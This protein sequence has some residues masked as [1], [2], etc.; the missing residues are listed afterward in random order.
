LAKASPEVLAQACKSLVGCE[1]AADYCTICDQERIDRLKGRMSGLNEASKAHQKGW[2]EAQ[3]KRGDARDR[4]WGKGEGLKFEGGSIA[5]FGKAGLDSVLLASGGGGGVG[6][7]YSSVT[8]NYR[9]VRDWTEKG[10]ALGSDPGN[11]ETWTGFGKDM[12]EMQADDIFRRRSTEAL[13]S[14]RE[15]FNKTGNYVG[16]Q[17]V[18]REKWGNYGR[19]KDFKG[20]AD[21]F[22]DALNK[23][24]N[25]Y[26][27]TD[28]VANDLQDWIDAYRDDKAAEREKN[29]IDDEMARIQKELDRLNAACG[30]APGS[31][32]GA[33]AAQPRPQ[34]LFLE[35]P[36]SAAAASPS[37]P[38]VL[39][40]AKPPAAA[41]PAADVTLERAQAALRQVR[42]LQKSLR[43]LDQ[44]LGKQLAA[45]LSPWFAGVNRDAEPLLL[46]ELVKASR[47]SFSQFEVTLNELSRAGTDAW[48]S[49]QAIPRDQGR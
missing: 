4:L 2:R 41:K 29:K 12:L 8:G 6:K 17:N 49:L 16:A 7:A 40:V 30:I 28:K 27:K 14:A 22:A 32:P 38:Q 5:D 10:W 19:L 33:A 9:K 11:V 45:P 23:L 25:L 39:T 1:A 36:P 48:S 15:H 13:R 20:K 34:P 18:Y 37:E 26:D 46:L 43:A 31:G 3:A 24:K 21:S 35:G 47:T 42:T 44:G